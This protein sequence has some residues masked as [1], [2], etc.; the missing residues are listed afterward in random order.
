[1][2]YVGISVAAEGSIIEPSTSANSAF[3]PRNWKYAKPN[4]TSAL[5]SVTAIAAAIPTT[6]LLSVHCRN[7]SC[8]STLA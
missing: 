2:R 8:S 1:M 3:L 4:A 5:D 6:T 7:G